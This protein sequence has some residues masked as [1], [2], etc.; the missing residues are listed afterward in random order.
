MRP[1]PTLARRRQSNSRFQA[2][3]SMWFVQTVRVGSNPGHSHFGVSHVRCRSTRGL[4]CLKRCCRV[5]LNS[6]NVVIPGEFPF[7][8]LSARQYLSVGTSIDV[9]SPQKFEQYVGLN[10]YFYASESAQNIRSWLRDLHL[11]FLKYEL[12]IH[13]FRTP[14]ALCDGRLRTFGYL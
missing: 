11:G 9:L 8:T 5:D 7:G 10:R 2:R 1:R 13:G 4:I 6:G 14:D 12:A 3:L